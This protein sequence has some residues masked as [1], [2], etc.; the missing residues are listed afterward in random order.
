[1]GSLQNVDQMKNQGEITEEV[2][3]QFG[4][5]ES[6]VLHFLNGENEEDALVP[7]KRH[8]GAIA[9]ISGSRSLTGSKSFASPSKKHLGSIAALSGRVAPGRKLELSFPSTVDMYKRHLASLMASSG[10]KPKS[11]TRSLK[12]SPHQMDSPL[13]TYEM[14]TPQMSYDMMN[15]R[16]NVV[17]P[18]ASTVDSDFVPENIQLPQ[19][20]FMGYAR[21]PSNSWSRN[22]FQPMNSPVIES[23]SSFNEDGLNGELG[24]G[25]N[26]DVGAYKSKRFLGKIQFTFSNNRV[27]L[28]MKVIF[29]K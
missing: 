4:P 15:S 16:F 2:G 1:M 5:P 12:E 7:Y 8:L 3:N 29:H 25:E 9:A 13:D 27:E 17:T 28:P 26:D 21:E 11:V 19:E 18:P 24:L 6:D 20:I 22:S 14:E 10:A 23:E